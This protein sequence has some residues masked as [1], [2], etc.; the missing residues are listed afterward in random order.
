MKDRKP[1]S[2]TA[3]RDGERY[4]APACGHGCT[5]VNFE[6][7]TLCAAQLVKDLGPDWEPR[8]HENMGWHASATAPHLYVTVNH[9]QNAISYTAFLNREPDGGCG[10]HWTADGA[11]PYDAVRLV[12]AEARGELE[13]MKSLVA[14]LE[15]GAGAV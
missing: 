15:K 13:G 7:A 2:W 5:W 9:Y 14:L 8:V 10:G 1:L 6:R 4:C 12:L 11:T 3:R